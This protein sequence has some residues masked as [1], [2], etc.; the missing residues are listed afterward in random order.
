LGSA[1][2]SKVYN[3]NT[4]AQGTIGVGNKVGSDDV[5]VLGLGSYTD[6]KNVGSTHTYSVVAQ[7]LSGAAAGNYYLSSLATYTGSNGVITAAPLSIT[8]ITATNKVYN[9][10]NSVTVSTANAVKTGLV[11]GDD[12]TVS[13]TGSFANKTAGTAKV[14]SLVSTYAGA[15]RTNYSITDQTSTTANITPAALTISGVTAA[16]KT[17]DGS[18]VASM[19]TAN[20]VTSGVLGADAVTVSA[21]GAFA[22]KN[23]GTAK[24]VTITGF[25]LGGADGGNYSIAGQASAS[26][27]I[28]PAALSISGIT[29]QNKTYDGNT[30]ATLN[31]AN[32]VKTGLVVGDVV[33][34]SATGQFAD[35]SVG[36]GKSVR[37]ALANGGADVDNYTI[38]DQATAM[39]DILAAS[40]TRPQAPSPS[41]IPPLPLTRAPRADSPNPVAALESGAVSRLSSMEITLVSAPSAQSQG[42]ISVVLPQGAADAGT[43]IVIPVAEQID[44]F[45]SGAAAR[46]ISVSLPNNLPLPSWIEYRAADSAFVLNTVPQGALPMLVAI[47]FKD[48]RFLVRI[49]ESGAVN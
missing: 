41:V 47:R 24:V 46:D 32:V 21:A 40:T 36:S 3:G 14:V 37:L 33:S 17:Y 16:N 49:S 43:Q 6:N 8:G 44:Q 28:T 48:V 7:Q 18:T 11:V 4:G 34:V 35:A 26:A 2:V 20:A 29:A 39:A 25:A 30:S 42:L 45:A 9:G 5:S 19:S 31:M 15:D 1:S 13:A 22:D 10:D 38:T 23:V 27:D 12:V